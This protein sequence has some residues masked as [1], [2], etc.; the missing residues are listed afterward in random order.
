MDDDQTLRSMVR[1]DAYRVVRVLGDGPSGRTELVTFGGEGL[2]VRKHIPAALANA[3]AWA[4]AMEVDE[5]LLPRIEEL[6]RMPD[7][8]VVVYDYVEGDAVNEVVEQEGR[9][10]ATRAVGMLVD[11]CRA[12][13]ALHERDVVHRD[14]TPGNVILASDGAHLV[15]LGIARQKRQ[16]QRRDT[17]TLG[18][19][20]FAAP[21]QYGFMQTDARSD[22]YAL[23]RLLGYA[24][25]GEKPDTEAYETALSDR[26][27]VPEAL[28][29]VVQKATAFEPSARYQTAGELARAAQ[30]ALTGMPLPEPVPEPVPTPEAAPQPAHPQ[31]PIRRA[32]RSFMEAPLYLRALAALAWIALV[33]GFLIVLAASV[34]YW[35]TNAPIWHA[36][37]YVMAVVVDAGIAYLCFEIYKAVCLRGAYA[38]ER[39]PVRLFVTR[40]CIYTLII[41]LVMM[42]LGIFVSYLREG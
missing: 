41:F 21:E 13:S 28:Y 39:H 20:G 14:I 24:L 11:V 8:L 34:T 32:S 27:I 9:L 37:Q 26:S 10:E 23:G 30:E 3:A 18:T 12:V 31:S 16:G 29:D 7:E 15:D 33:V 19:W 35:M 22:V 38:T 25:T 4:V 6:Y 40:I 1:D 36:E 2:L 5:P 17:T 42:A